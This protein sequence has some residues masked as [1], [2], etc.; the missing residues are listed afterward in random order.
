[1]NPKSSTIN[2]VFFGSTADSVIVLD[3]LY[4]HFFN[5][6][7]SQS[8]QISHLSSSNS[9]SA[10][11]FQLLT[12]V[13]QP[14]KPV[15]RSSKPQVTPVERWA[16][17]HNIVVLSFPTDPINSWKYQNL[18]EVINSIKSLKPDLIISTSYGQKIPADVI[19]KTKYGGINVHPSLL[20]RFRGADPTPWVLMSGDPTTGATL[21][22][23][24]DKFDQGLI[25]AQEKIPVSDNDLTESL[26]HKTFLLGAELLVKT[27]PD[28]ILGKIAGSPQNLEKSTTARRLTRQDGFIPWG[29]LNRVISD[30]NIDINQLSDL[31]II[32]DLIKQKS[33]DPTSNP[34]I[35][36]ERMIRALSPWP[37]VWTEVTVSSNKRQETG[38]KRLKI[39]SAFLKDNML[40]IDQVQ[41][42]GKNPVDYQQFIRDHML[43]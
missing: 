30:D 13:T 10:F 16:K 20:P 32:K 25:L 28:F 14:P 11:G 42:E 41:L 37:G 15:G 29:L 6:Q 27:L 43:K 3:K 26:R 22:T 9:P 39:L 1:V 7:Q 19:K 40:L 33:F 23:L 8:S 5:S 36:V 12:V 38:I 17:D 35:F 18:N 34:V 21:I 24:A 31:I 2:T 4:N